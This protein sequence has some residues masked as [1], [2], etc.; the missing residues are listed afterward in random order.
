MLRTNFL[1]NFRLSGGPNGR[2]TRGEEIVQL[3]CMK[4][5]VTEDAFDRAHFKNA[6]KSLIKTQDEMIK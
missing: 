6:E 5:L 2:M 3:D 4:G 1:Q